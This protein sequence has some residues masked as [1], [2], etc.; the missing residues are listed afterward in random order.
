[1]DISRVLEQGRVKV[2]VRPS[3]PKN[4]IRG[5]DAARQALR[6]DIQAPPEQGKANKELVKFLSKTWKM[7]VELIQGFTSKEKYLRILR[8]DL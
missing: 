7:K 3:R 2:L 5:W 1:M 8:K 4:A 6:V